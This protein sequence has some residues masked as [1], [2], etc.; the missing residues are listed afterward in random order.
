MMVDYVEKAE[1]PE[2]AVEKL[3]KFDLVKDYM[4]K[5]YGEG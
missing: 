1:F 4:S 5:P 3:K 2:R